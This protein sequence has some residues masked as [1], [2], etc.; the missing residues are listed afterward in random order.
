MVSLPIQAKTTPSP[1]PAYPAIKKNIAFWEKV[2]SV[3]STSTAVVHD[4]NDLLKIYEL[5]PISDYRIFGSSKKNKNVLKRT[6]RKYKKILLKL[7]SGKK[8]VTRTE[9]KVAR[10]YKKASR[11]RLRKAAD[12]IRIQIGQKERFREGVIHSGQ[13]MKAIKKIFVNNGLPADLAYLPHVESSFNLKAYSKHGAAG[14]WQFTRSTGKNYL[15]ID[16]VVDERLNPIQAS[17]AAA[18]YLKKAHQT[19]NSWPLAITA[20][21]YGPAGMKRAQKKYGDYQKIFKHYKK[22]HFKFASRNFYSEFLAA[23][24]VA[25]RLE[26]KKSLKRDRPR[27]TITLKLKGF[28]SADDICHH[29]KIN[30][31]TLK[32]LNYSLLHPVL[33]GKKYIPKGFSLQLPAQ[34]KTKQLIASLPRSYYKSSQRR[35]RFYRVKRGDTL[36]KIA[37]RHKVSLKELLAINNLKKNAVIY[38]GRRMRIPAGHAGSRATVP[39]LIT[40]TA[41]RKTN[42]RTQTTTGPQPPRTIRPEAGMKKKK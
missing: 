8:P 35:S 33:S 27:A 6:K 20:Y 31:S 13:Y 29:F 18:L 37:R 3:Y 24:R 5:V 25:K 2:Y 11:A 14:I 23:V 40:P 9:K 39:I 26:R 7:A 32:R 34:K 41:K 42:H 38:S 16:S 17:R 12:A 21:N 36:G 19:L 15:R 28:I 30:T 4:Q 22:G 10:L 1:F